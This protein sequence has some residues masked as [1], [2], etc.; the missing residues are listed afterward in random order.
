MRT[1]GV[2]HEH[3]RRHDP[4]RAVG[5]GQQLLGHHALEGDRE[6]DPHLALLVGGEHVDDAVDRLRGVLRVQRREHEV[7]GLSRG[8]RGRD[9][10]EVAHLS[11]EDH[12]GVLAQR[13][14]QR[15]AEAL[16]VGAE[17]ALVDEAL[18]VPVQELDR[19]LDRHD[20]LL[21]RAV[22]LVDHRGERGGLPRAGRARDEDEAARPAREL[23]DGG[24]QAELVDARHP[25]RDQAERRPDR[26]PLVVGVYAE[27]GVARDRVGEV[28]LPVRLQTLALVAREDRVDDL[29]GV[30]G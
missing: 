12:V 3:L 26:S 19:V 11:D 7:P 22:D 14:L 2:R 29:A 16:R 5:V 15:V 13:R 10:L 17:L 4:A 27:A 23:V 9:R 25:E 8:Q 18:L 1:A 6:L 30:G 20:V 21:A 24:R 28:E